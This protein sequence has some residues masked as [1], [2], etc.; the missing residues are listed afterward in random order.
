M[1][2]VPWGLDSAPPRRSLMYPIPWGLDSAPSRRSLRP[3][4]PRGAGA[5]GGAHRGGVL[6][7]TGEIAVAARRIEPNGRNSRSREAY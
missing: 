1:Y 5:G 4:P 7:P 3:S 2:P 6:S